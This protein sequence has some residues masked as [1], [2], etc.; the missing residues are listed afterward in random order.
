M[1]V[2][3][4]S[5]FS[6]SGNTRLLESF[7]TCKTPRYDWIQRLEAL[8]VSWSSFIKIPWSKSIVSS[9]LSHPIHEFKWN[10]T[11]SVTVHDDVWRRTIPMCLIR[12]RL[13]LDFNI[14]CVQVIASDEI[15]DKITSRS[16]HATYCVT[17]SVPHDP[18]E[19]S[20]IHEEY[21]I[22]KV[23]FFSSPDTSFSRALIV[24]LSRLSS[25]LRMHHILIDLINLFEYLTCQVRETSH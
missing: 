11:D 19:I 22:L 6:V 7:V 13:A 15:S 24:S 12:S 20:C 5:W 17:S 2:T 14:N 25:L 23:F 4:L 21:V 9:T 18:L 3:W 1:D 8:L 10:L 16:S